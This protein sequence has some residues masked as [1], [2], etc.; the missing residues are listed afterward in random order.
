MPPLYRRGGAAPRGVR[1]PLEVPPPLHHGGNPPHHMSNP[2]LIFFLILHD[3][4]VN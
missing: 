3:I 1:C 2:S 4:H